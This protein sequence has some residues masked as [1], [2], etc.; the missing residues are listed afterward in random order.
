M[1]WRTSSA[2]RSAVSSAP[3][4]GA[5][6]SLPS[7]RRAGSSFLVVHCC[8][9]VWRG[10]MGN[11]CVPF[12]SRLLHSCHVG[13]LCVSPR[14]APAGRRP[15]AWVWFLRPPAFWKGPHCVWSRTTCGPAL[16]VVLHHLQSRTTCSPAPPGVLH[17]LRS[18][19]TGGPVLENF[20][21]SSGPVS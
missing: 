13:S 21:C 20:L 6:P 14:R 11:A 7:P 4:A 17:H 8:P 12:S 5:L 10:H 16:R 2:A 18:R 19:T 9:L 3:T 1:R 15:T